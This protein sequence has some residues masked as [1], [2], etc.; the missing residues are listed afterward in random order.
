MYISEFNEYRSSER[1]AGWNLN[2]HEHTI[3][4]TLTISKLPHVP[5]AGFCGTKTQSN[6]K[7]SD[8]IY[9]FS[10]LTFKFSVTEYEL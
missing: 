7:I 5:L 6:P 9:A 8:Q 4:C 3:T 2:P 10:I 1:Q